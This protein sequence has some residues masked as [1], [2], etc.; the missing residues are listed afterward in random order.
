M[1]NKVLVSVYAVNIDEHYDI[2]VPI[3]YTIG[4]MTDLIY[5]TIKKLSDS[6]L[7]LKNNYSL[8]DAE[9]GDF[10]NFDTLVSDTDIRN[11]KKFIIFC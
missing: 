2:Y 6:N 7:K 9:K 8:L 4:Q 11:G 5:T 10:Y 3:N 1:K